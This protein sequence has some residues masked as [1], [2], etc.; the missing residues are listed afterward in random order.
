MISDSNPIKETHV[1]DFST[2]EKIQESIDKIANILKKYSDNYE[3]LIDDS[4]NKS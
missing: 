1:F 4:L 3:K 2:N